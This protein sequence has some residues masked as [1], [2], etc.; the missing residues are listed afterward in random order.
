MWHT[1]IFQLSWDLKTH[2]LFLVWKTEWN[3]LL[4][5]TYHDDTCP[6]KSGYCIGSR[7]KPS[8]RGS[9]VVAAQT[10]KQC[11]QYKGDS[12]RFTMPLREVKSMPRFAAIYANVCVLLIWRTWTKQHSWWHIRNV[13][14]TRG[15]ETQGM[16]CQRCLW[17]ES[18]VI[19]WTAAESGPYETNKQST[20]HPVE[21]IF[22]CSEPQGTPGTDLSSP[23]WLLTTIFIR[24]W[25]AS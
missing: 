3:G 6:I 16:S 23:R 11:H 15:Y 10:T 20:P 18:I 12:I 5:Y 1:L 21:V 24:R 22:W 14:D 13:F 4:A 7:T 2:E 9:L 19:K 8:F 25:L 17:M